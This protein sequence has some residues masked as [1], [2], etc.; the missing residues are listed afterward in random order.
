MAKFPSNPKIGQSFIGDPETL[1]VWNGHQWKEVS[2]LNGITLTSPTSYYVSR[3]FTQSVGSNSS[4]ET[5]L[6]KLTIPANTFSETD[7]IAFF[8]V[9]S[10]SGTATN[11]THRI[12]ISTSASMPTGTTNQIAQF[13]STNTLIFTKI[14]RELVISQGNIKAYPATSSAVND[15]GTAISAMSSIAF[16]VTQTQYLYVSATPVSTTTDVTYLEAFEIRNI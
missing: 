8:A 12:K 1:Y 9:F 11:T 2:G 4:G 14:N 10:K 15:A 16:D 3:S 13:A 6:L 7:K 5:Q